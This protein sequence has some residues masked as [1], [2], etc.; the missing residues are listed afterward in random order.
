MQ[1]IAWFWKPVKIK[2]AVLS[3]F[4]F[5]LIYIDFIDF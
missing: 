2:P 5:S 1:L 3:D 4:L